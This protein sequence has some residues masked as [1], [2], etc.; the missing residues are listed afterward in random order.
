MARVMARSGYAA[1]TVDLIAAESGVSR[2]A[3]YTHFS[4]KEDLLLEAH[5][6][7]VQ[8][9][10]AGAGPSVAEQQDWREGLRVLLDWGLEL[11]A[12]EPELANLSLVEVS[13]ATPASRRLHRETIDR[14]RA[15]AEQATVDCSRSVPRT[16]IEGMIGGM[17][18]L[19]AQAAEEEDAAELPALRGQLMA[20]FLLVFEGPEAAQSELHRDG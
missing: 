3:L 19:I 12:R 5:R 1:T 2:K 17:I 13:A 14:L 11:F 9:I 7:V 16:A 4:G 15:L 18:Y 6:A 8:R 10:A 20:W